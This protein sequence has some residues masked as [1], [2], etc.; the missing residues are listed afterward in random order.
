MKVF[1]YI[2]DFLVW[3]FVVPQ[4]GEALWVSAAKMFGVIIIL[5]FITW[6]LLKIRSGH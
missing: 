3:F 5:Y 2:D 4:T 1:G 6:I